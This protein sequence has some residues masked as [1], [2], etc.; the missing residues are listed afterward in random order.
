MSR[1]A[2]GSTR[3]RGDITEAHVVPR[4]RERGLTLVERNV[5]IGGAELDIIAVASDRT[6][7]FIEVRGRS[8]EAHGRPIETVDAR[9]QRQVIRAATTWLVHN[10]L[11]ERVPVRFDVV[12]VTHPP[13]AKPTVEWIEN[14]FELA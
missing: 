14:A 10:S 8:S 4:L 13:N 11:W 5:E 1:F 12:G 7:V 6:H 9:K 2:P 3:A